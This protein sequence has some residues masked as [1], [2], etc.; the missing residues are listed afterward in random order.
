MLQ[1][2]L[3]FEKLLAERRCWE[4]NRDKN[5]QELLA[6]LVQRF[7]AFRANSAIRKWQLSEDMHKA[8]LNVIVGLDQESRDLLRAHLNYNKWEERDAWMRLKCA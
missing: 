1:V 2:S 8:V 6:E 4:T 3:R 7:N 5:D